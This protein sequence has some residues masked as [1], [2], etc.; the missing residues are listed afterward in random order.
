[1]RARVS[2]I[3]ARLSAA[4]GGNEVARTELPGGAV[5][6]DVV[7]PADISSAGRYVVLAALADADGYGHGRTES[8]ERVWATIDPGTSHDPYQSNRSPRPDDRRLPRQP[9]R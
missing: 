8:E 6:L 5:R 7:I 9:D 2:H 3:A 1:M 4:T